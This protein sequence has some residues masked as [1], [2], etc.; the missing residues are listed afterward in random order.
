MPV[1]LQW[2]P[3]SRDTWETLFDTIPRS[4]L[5][6]SWA[7]GEAKQRAQR[8][9][10]RRGIVWHEARPIALIQTL[11]YS[12]GPLCVVRCNRGPLW[13]GTVDDA[14]RND[15]YA[16]LRCSARWWRGRALLIAPEL[17]D[18]RPLTPALERLGYRRRGAARWRSAWIDLSATPDHLRASLDRRWR[19]HLHQA[20]RS[21]IV[22]QVDAE[23]SSFEWLMERYR[24]LIAERRFSG[25]DIE[26]LA[27]LRQAQRKSDDMLVVYATRGMDRVAGMLTVRHGAAATYVVGWT[28]DEGR[29]LNAQHLVLWTALRELK[30]RGCG[31]FDVGGID[32]HATPGIASFKRGLKGSEYNLVGEFFAL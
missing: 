1:R 22:V 5:L 11:E 26:L 25:I 10:I 12:F 29:K 3:P 8:T 15:T 28:G 17:D 20:E 32:A 16:A 14:L 24:T 9:S 6:Q 31:A 19:N 13:L 27:N 21:G 2:E 23:Q 4:N 18:K 30:A 7:Y